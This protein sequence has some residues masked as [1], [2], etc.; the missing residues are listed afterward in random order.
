MP[1]PDELARYL[2]A[3]HDDYV[4]KVNRAVADN[5]EDLIKDLTDAYAD[6]ALAA[7]TAPSALG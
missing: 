7:M 3:L 6:E 5:R 2:R 4:D 1:Q